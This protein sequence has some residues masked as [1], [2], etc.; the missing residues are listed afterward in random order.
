MLSEPSRFLLDL[1]PELI[2]GDL[3][4]PHNWV[5]TSYRQQTTWER[6]QEKTI[7]P[8]FRAGMRVRH[9]VFGEGI[10]LSTRV[11]FDDEEISIEFI[12]V[13][14]KNLVASIANLEIMDDA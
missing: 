1:P 7:E 13:G 10:V 14:L 11:D 3:P 6:P 8:R 2:D 5:E 9:P 12:D 4:S